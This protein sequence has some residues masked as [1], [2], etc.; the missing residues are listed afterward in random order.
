MKGQ[1]HY[2]DEQDGSW[3]VLD[4]REWK[5]KLL[6]QVWATV[7]AVAPKLCPQPNIHKLV[8]PGDTEAMTEARIGEASSQTEYLFL[9]DT[10]LERYQQN[11]IYDTVPVRTPDGVWLCSPSYGGQWSFVGCQRFGRNLVRVSVYELYKKAVPEREIMHA[12]AH[13]IGPDEVAQYS[14]DE[15]HLPAKV[16]RLLLQLLDLAITF[17]SSATASACNIRMPKR[18]WASRGRSWRRTVGCV[19]R[20]YAAWHRWPPWP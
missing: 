6:V 12:H 7:P 9:R 1:A 20:R 5:G 15:E 13:A 17:H 4:I 10:F 18:S 16:H 11:S 3:Y 2:L 8:W 14:A 19:T